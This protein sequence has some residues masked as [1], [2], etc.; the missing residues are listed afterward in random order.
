MTKLT[1]ISH[2]YNEEYLLPFWLQ[3]HVD[4]VDHGVMINHRSTDGSVEIIKKY[5]P[6]WEIIES[7]LTEFD[8]YETDFEVQCIESRIEGWKICLNTTE[9]LVGPVRSLIRHY[10]DKGIRSVYTSAKIMID[11]DPETIPEPNMPLILSKPE[12]INDNKIY[13]IFIRGPLFRKVVGFLR[14]PNSRYIGRQRLLHRENIGRYVVGRHQWGHRAHY[15]RQLC[16]NWYSFSP[17]NDPFI[18]RKLGIAETMPKNDDGL[19]VHHRFTLKQWQ[20]EYVLHLILLKLA[21]FVNFKF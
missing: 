13:D 11:V 16:V 3:H 2:F 18:K 4:L 20:N 8:P 7:S 10:E 14:K 19:G 1:L 17:W 9:F 21:K 6:N 5:A 15:E 12:G